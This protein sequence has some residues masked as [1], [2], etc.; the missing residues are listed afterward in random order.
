MWIKSE[1]NLIEVYNQNGVERPPKT[2][3]RKEEEE[4][5]IMS[6]EKERAAWQAVNVGCCLAYRCLNCIHIWL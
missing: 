1:K 4:N 3:F 6:G 2:N 5:A